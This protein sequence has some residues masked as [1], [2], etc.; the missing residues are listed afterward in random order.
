MRKTGCRRWWRQKTVVLHD[1]DR[2]I[3]IE[4]YDTNWAADY[5]SSLFLILP[6]DAMHSADCAVA[7][8]RTIRPPFCPSL[9]RRNSIE[10]AKHVSNFLNRLVA[11][12]F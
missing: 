8:Y 7:R 2:D 11:T 10:T 6:R 4:N 12:P 5:V 1:R 9:I 3:L